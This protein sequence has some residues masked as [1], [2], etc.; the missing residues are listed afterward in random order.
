MEIMVLHLSDRG[1][2]MK[3]RGEIIEPS[4]QANLTVTFKD[5]SGMHVSTDTLPTISI[6]QPSGLVMLAPTSVGVMQHGPGSYSYIFTAPIA[7]PLGVWNDIWTGYIN[8]FRIETTFSFIV[9]NGQIPAIDSDGKPHLGGDLGFHYSECATINLDKLIKAVKARLNSAGKAK[10]KDAY[11]NDIVVDCDIISVDMITTFLSTALWEFNQIPYFT[12]FTFNDDG[13]VDQFGQIIVEGAVLYALASLALIEQARNYNITDNGI[14]FTPPNMG[15][16]LNT[17]YGNL[18]TQ[19]FE[20]LKYIKNSIRPG[21]L[22]LGIF[23]MSSGLNPAIRR[24]QNLRARRV[25]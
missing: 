19:H 12:H 21:P 16:M 22:G 23:G 15:E 14:S 5:P 6:V 8:G 11:G 9:N 4:E 20:K 25:F 3:N 1:A 10:A 18:L 7:G 17:Q 24:L 2:V 13:F